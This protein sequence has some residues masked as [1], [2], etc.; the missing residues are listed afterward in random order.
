MVDNEMCQMK[1]LD[2]IE[3]ERE[4]F[5][6]ALNSFLMSGKRTPICVDEDNGSETQC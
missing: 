5:R 6:H 3:N 2:D 4:D 1:A